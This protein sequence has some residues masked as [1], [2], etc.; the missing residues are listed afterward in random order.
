[1]QFRKLFSTFIHVIVWVLFCTVPLLIF[2]G[3][4]FNRTYEEILTCPYYLLFNGS[5]I[6]LFYFTTYFLIPRF[7]LQKKFVAYGIS[8]F[9]MFVAFFFLKPFELMVYYNSP[10]D[11]PEAYNPFSVDIMANFLFLVIVAMGIA[12]QIIWQWRLA[13]FR[14]QKAEAEKMQAE[15]EKMQA[16]A[17][18][19][20]AE[21]S[22]LKAQINPHFLFNTLN[23][24]YS[25]AVHESPQTAPSIMKLS[26]IMRYV[27]DDAT[28]D[29]V[30]LERE[31]DCIQDYINLQSLRLGENNIVN[32]KVCGETEDK[33]IAPLILM[34][35][36]ENLFKYGITT[37]NEATMT[38]RVCSDEDKIT[39]FSQ[40]RIM[41]RGNSLESTGIG[42]V[43]TQQRLDLVY[44]DKHTLDIN[45]ENGLFTVS[46]TLMD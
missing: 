35:F 13:Q 42:L 45:E 17:D 3:R 14:A 10:P 38:I 11:R 23:N 20:T 24:I 16:L 29:F 9:L 4:P 5:F 2:S 28:Q 12:L 41:A 22:F 34:T 37:R 27:T 25:L 31:L 15:A 21:L 30:T 40:N 36:I 33:F 44:P 46:L 26:N 39:F 32:F 19:K 8:M 18:K 7:Y 1:M 43:N 6:F